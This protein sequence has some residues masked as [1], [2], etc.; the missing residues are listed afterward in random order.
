MDILTA[1][2]WLAAVVVVERGARQ[3]IASRAVAWIAAYS[4]LGV[5][6]VA[7]GVGSPGG[8]PFG[9][10]AAIGLALA[11][12]GYPLGRL[13]LRDVPSSPP[14]DKL[15]TELAALAGFVAV[16]EELLWGAIVEP[17]VGIVATSALFAVK[18]PL[19]DGRW[20]RTL[21]LFLFW[22]G[23]GLVRAWSW[24]VAIALH[25]GLNA[26]GVLLGH[27]TGRDQF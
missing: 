12:V 13:L 25:I 24:P 4:L 18:H 11:I 2:G 8:R 20:R 7:V 17:A 3:L 9:P 15:P 5:A 26:G 10:A 27:R 19:V 21:G 23:L 6:A 16:A 22:L 1:F 14:Q